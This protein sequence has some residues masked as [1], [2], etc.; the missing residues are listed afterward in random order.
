MARVTQIND[1]RAN[2]VTLAL[3]RKIRDMLGFVPNLYRAAA[4]QPAVLSALLNLESELS[5]GNFD[6]RTRKA[7]GLAISAANRSDYCVSAF[8]AISKDLMVDDTEIAERLEGK[9]DNT[10]LQAKLSFA[11][12]VL[13][14]YGRIS[15]EDID[16]AHKA[17]LSDGDIMEIVG[18]VVESIFTNYINNVAQPEIDFPVVR[19]RSA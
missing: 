6:P 5:R 18:N 17:G 13:E 3:F 14:K 11:L 16:A 1:E 4:S 10:R 2:P 7:I 12:V 19:T 9:S 8:A 15:D